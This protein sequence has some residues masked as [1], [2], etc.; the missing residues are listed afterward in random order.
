MLELLQPAEGHTYRDFGLQKLSELARGLGLAGDLE[1]ATRLFD[2]LTS[3]WS[4]RPLLRTSPFPSDVSEDGTPF[5]FSV[6]FTGERPLL[7]LQAEARRAP[8]DVTSNWEAGLELTRGLAAL[9]G[10]DIE[11]FEAIKSLFAPPAGSTARFSLLHAG[12]V[13]PDGTLS[14]KV[15]LNPRILGAS[16]ATELVRAALLQLDADYAWEELEQ[17]LPVTSEL[18]YFSVDLAKSTDARVKVYVAHP[19]ATAQSIDELVAHESGY[20]PGLAQSFIEELTGSAGPFDARPIVT[21]HG[22]RSALHA[23]DVTVHVPTSSYVGDD[24]ECLGRA[25]ELVGP[26]AA[27]LR[28]GVESMAGRPLDMGRGLVTSVALCPVADGMRVTAYLSPEAHAISTPRRKS[29]YADCDP[30][31]PTMLSSL[32]ALNPGGSQP[33]SSIRAL[34]VLHHGQSFAVVEELVTASAEALA[35]HQLVRRLEGKGSLP[36]MRALVRRFAFYVLSSKD[37][38]RLARSRMKDP[39]VRSV[40]TAEDA[41]L[42][43]AF[44]DDL[45]ALGAE[46]D[47]AFAFS[48]EYATTRDATYRVMSEIMAATHDAT[49]LAVL[50]SLDAIGAEFL[51]RFGGYLYRLGCTE[52]LRFFTRSSRFVAPGHDVFALDGQKPLDRILVSDSAMPEVIRAVEQTFAAMACL[53][54]EIESSMAACS[55][56]SAFRRVG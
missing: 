52:E 43:Q 12:A 31:A 37:L 51:G 2:L 15:Y 32:G 3:S 10:V 13:E 6:A 55:D 46:R 45:E 22:F 23:G 54:D 7:R 49:R 11:R 1:A 48:P 18:V 33:H 25:S 38:V 26:S 56:D 53:G 42:E 39:D 27:L 41:E 24:A 36:E 44:L 9:P 28:A 14:F 34:G 19:H 8:F 29:N 30:K 40:T 4:A 17:K 47:L 16:H 20:R 50:L 35:T 21:C 5:E